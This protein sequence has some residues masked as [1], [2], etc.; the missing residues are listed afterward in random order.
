MRLLTDRE[1]SATAKLLYGLIE[2]YQ[3][4]SGGICY[5][6]NASLASIMNCDLFTISRCIRNLREAGYIET[7]YIVGFGREMHTCK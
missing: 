6:T 1:V 7:T 2:Y 5:E 4:M 3:M